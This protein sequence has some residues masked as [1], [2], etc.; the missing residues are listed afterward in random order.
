[1]SNS[2]ASEQEEATEP[3]RWEM[4][5][6]C[7]CVIIQ[8]IGGIQETARPEKTE[9]MATDLSGRFKRVT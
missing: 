1:M 3:K 7:I 8:S 9:K 6:N 2:D 4:S 5:A